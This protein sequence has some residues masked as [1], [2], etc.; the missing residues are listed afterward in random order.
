MRVLV[1]RALRFRQRYFHTN[2]KPDNWTPKPSNW[3]NPFLT[4]CHHPEGLL[5]KPA[6]ED[7]VDKAT[8][9]KALLTMISIKLWRKYPKNLA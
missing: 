9:L 5:F 2:P 1:R 8:R 6:M 3:V 4:C 7:L